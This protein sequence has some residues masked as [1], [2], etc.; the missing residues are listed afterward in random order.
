MQLATLARKIM[1]S[2]RNSANVKIGHP[3]ISAP[4]EIAR[5]ANATPEDL[6]YCFRMLLGRSPG[7]EEWKFHCNLAQN[8]KLDDL[9]M[10]FLNSPEFEQRKN[11]LLKKHWDDDLFLKKFERFSIYV[12][13][14]DVVVGRGIKHGVYEPDVTSVFES[15]LKEGMNVLDL[16]GNIGYFTML[17]SA[18]VKASGSVVV[19]EP[20]PEN[21][22]LI[23]LSRRAN[24]FD[25]I[26][27]VQA[28]VWHKLEFLVLRTDYSNGT[29]F[30]L[31]GDPAQLADATTVSCLRVDDVIAADKP[32][33]F[34]KIDVEGAEYNALIGASELVK[35]CHPLIVS[36]FS[37]ILLQ[38]VGG[39]DA[40]QYLKLLIDFG[41]RMSVIEPNGKLTAC[42]VNIDKVMKAYEDSGGDHID[43][44]FE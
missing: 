23:E 34:I 28:G 16:G 13:E 17:S 14:S 15:R 38:N 39:V 18:L 7:Q 25:N 11:Q 21:T 20:N 22:K 43:I 42:D 32:I 19:F 29:L 36:E 35:R 6:F 3:D 5:H 24:N 1:K 30:G 44:L 31:S 8:T 40:R 26:T 4:W 10:Y 27:I 41:Y 9:L 37:P 2:V 33:H 12:R